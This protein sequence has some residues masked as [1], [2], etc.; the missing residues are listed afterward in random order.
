MAGLCK[1][2]TALVVTPTLSQLTRPQIHVL[3][4]EPKIFL[5]I[6]THPTWDFKGKKIQLANILPPF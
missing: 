6:P 1:S 5:L 3:F 4:N 2:S